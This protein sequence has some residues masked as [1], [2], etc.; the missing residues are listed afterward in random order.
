MKHNLFIY[1]TLRDD[2]VRQAIFGTSVRGPRD[3]L[4]GYE[5]TST[6]LPGG[7]Y[8]NLAR[9]GGSV[10]VGEVMEVDDA[11]LARTDAYETSHYD[12]REMKL[13]SGVTAWVYIRD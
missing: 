1:G 12:R 9:R 13:R 5:V 11:T 3:V 4:E 2:G 10:V 6:Q 7:A 8:P